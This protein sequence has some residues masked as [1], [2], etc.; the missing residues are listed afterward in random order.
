MANF[1]DYSVIAIYTLVVIGIGIYFSR[2]KK[3][4]ETY[5]L[6]G[7]SM[8][9]WAIG[10]ACMM[11]LFSS[12]SIVMVPGEIYNHGLTLFIV[13]G[14]LGPLLVVPAYM[15]FT[16]FY[17]QLGSF[18]PYEYLEF[19]YDKY[20]RGVVAFSSFYGRV[21]YI[22]LVLYTSAKIFEA[23]YHWPPWFSILLVSTVGIACCF[24]GGSK[25]V[26]WTDVFQAIITFGG[27]LAVTLMLC[28]KIDGG[29]VEAIA[30]AF[31]EGHGLPQ[32]SQP[33]FYTLSPY[34]RLLF[35]LLVWNTFTGTI[36]NAAS[37]QVTVQR[38][39][40]TKNWQEGLKAQITSTL[41]GMVF[42][43]FLY[44]IGLA[45]YTYYHQ[46]PCPTLT[47]GKGDAAF[48][49]F[50]ADFIPP[51]LSGL[52]M[53]AMLA[54]IMSTVS[55]VVNSMAAVWLK[56]FHQK[57]INKNMS[58]QDEFRV[59]RLATLILGGFGIALALAL[60]FSGKWLQQSVSEVG[61][62]FGLL[63][64]AILPAF[65]FAVLSKRA[66]PTLIWVY[67]CWAFGEGIAMNVWYAMSRSS[68]QAW[69][70]DPSVGFGWAGKFSFSYVAPYLVIGI[71]LVLPYLIRKWRKTKAAKISALT[72]CLFLGA[73]GGLAMWW[74]FSN[75][76]IT[77][78]PQ[79]RSFAFHL[80]LSF[81]GAFIILWF[82]PEQPKEKYQGLTLATLGQPILGLDKKQ[83]CA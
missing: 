59:L 63:G 65:L 74:F 28:W 10:L 33:E 1:L 45:L 22:G 77:D 78:V 3:D 35:F 75:L 43:F 80:P 2:E 15:L 39:L 58:E 57:F 17:F 41:S 8:P 83:E 25:A 55:G 48:F 32:F 54:A 52:F 12:I 5:L 62:L 9:H 37:D 82:C 6:G 66:N 30:C 46:N 27:L 19:R 70:K 61:T 36:V 53:A 16:R 11:S 29:F 40:S 56:E 23:G 38:V 34:V 47:A 67:T 76:L 20:V 49:Q 44:F 69:E 4:A 14:V 72:G 68:L 18:T 42:M 24:L 7:R 51:P 79:A 21:I 26:V 60:E 50:V 81:I 73:A 64:A 31:R 13:S 71:V